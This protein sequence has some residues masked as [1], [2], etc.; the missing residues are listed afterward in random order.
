MYN[1]LCSASIQHT[2]FD[3]LIA[4]AT[5]IFSKENPVATI[6]MRLLWACV[7]AARGVYMD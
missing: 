6:Q 5:I 1:V 4:A 2:I 3:R 7:A